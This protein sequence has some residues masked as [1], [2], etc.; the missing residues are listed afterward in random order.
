MILRIILT[1]ISFL[2]LGAHFDRAGFF[3]IMII[4]LLIPFLLFIKKRYILTFIQIILY[5]GAIEWV[6][7]IVIIAKLRIEIDQEWI[8]MAIIL[9]VVAI[10]TAI[11]GILL[12]S[13]K[14]KMTYLN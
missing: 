5:F 11:S 14:I 6:R 13:Q 1:T 4:C 9:G 2:L 12:N 10:F 8:K 3:A 7:T